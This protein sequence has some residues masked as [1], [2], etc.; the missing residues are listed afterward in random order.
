MRCFVAVELPEEV[1]ARVKELQ[2]QL[3]SCDVKLVEEQNL[4][5]TL[6]FL[7]EIDNS[8]IEEIKQ[9]LSEL[10][11]NLS[12]FSVLLSSVGAFPDLTY[13]KVIWIGT[14]SKDFI[15]LHKSVANALKGVGKEDKE[16]VPHLTIARVRSPRGK[17]IIQKII[18]RY[19]QESFGSFTADKIKLKKSTL[20][21]RGPVYEDLA[22]FDLI[23]FSSSTK[24]N[25]L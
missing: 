22:V 19:E 12:S 25:R 21:P 20:T 16:A 3:S 11:K 4:H 18:R 15:N 7:G 23:P 6:K 8:K 17:E 9:K 10:A 14:K 24:E 13:I 1:K 2:D 5:F